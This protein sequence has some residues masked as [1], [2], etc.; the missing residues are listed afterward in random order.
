SEETQEKADAEE[1][2]AQV[3][4]PVSKAAYDKL[5]KEYRELQ[6]QR[7]KIIARVSPYAQK[8][9]D[10]E[11]EQAK[12]ESEIMGN[13][14]KALTELANNPIETIRMAARAEI[15]AASQ[16]QFQRE[17]QVEWQRVGD[18]LREYA[19]A[20]GV[21]EATLGAML[22]PYNGFSGVPPVKAL[23]LAKLLVDKTAEPQKDKERNALAVSEADKM[24]KEKLTRRTPASV[25]GG[26]ASSPAKSAD[27]Q[28]W[29]G[30][31][32]IKGKKIANV[33]LK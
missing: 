26:S 33:F 23:E 3:V 28:F 14:D 32:A 8:I 19:D 15:Q 24:A 18:E 11:A 13:R 1:T 16:Q 31:D 20:H 10:W 2:P 22:Q 17:Q 9:A 4:A 29:E 12:K 25:P 5:Q 21:D 6:G 7:D 30:M 27:D